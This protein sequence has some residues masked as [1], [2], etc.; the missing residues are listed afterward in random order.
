MPLQVANMHHLFVRVC[1]STQRWG[2]VSQLLL[3]WWL[4]DG[5][6]SLKI[7][8]PFFIIYLFIWSVESPKSL[9][10]PRSLL[11][12]F[13]ENGVCLWEEADHRRREQNLEIYPTL[14][15]LLHHRTVGFN[16]IAV[17]P[18]MLLTLL[19]PKRYVAKTVNLCL[20]L[21]P[22]LCSSWFC[23]LVNTRPWKLCLLSVQMCF[24]R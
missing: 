7:T 21:P 14:L 4:E 16:V 13:F 2:S 24:L 18:L 8:P 1:G 10:F 5:P 12:S 9:S 20:L 15:C 6:C 3:P 22:L 17:L 23:T 11:R 19:V